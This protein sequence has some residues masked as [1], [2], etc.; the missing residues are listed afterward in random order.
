MYPKIYDHTGQQLAILDNI[1]KESAS[2]KRVVNGELPSRL[3][4]S[5]RN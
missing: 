5:R 1:I 4:L 2:I 3:K